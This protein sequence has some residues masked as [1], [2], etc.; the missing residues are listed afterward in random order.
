MTII[1]VVSP[2][3]AL[4]RDRSII[5]DSMQVLSVIIRSGDSSDFPASETEGLN[6][7]KYR[8]IYRHPEA[9]IGKLKK[10]LDSVQIREKVK[11]VVVDEAHL[12]E[13]W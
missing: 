9:Y 1:L 12:I 2:L 11:A 6:Q 8:I 3:N 10:V 4:M 7:C 13:E 5:V